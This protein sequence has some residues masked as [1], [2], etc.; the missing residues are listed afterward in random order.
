MVFLSSTSSGLGVLLLSLS[1][2]V[3]NLSSRRTRICLI[4]FT[5]L[6]CFL[7]LCQTHIESLGYVYFLR[8]ELVTLFPYLNNVDT[9]IAQICCKESL[10]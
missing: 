8:D 9:D 4:C 1:P 10:K 6:H 5:L 2:T 3:L 7:K